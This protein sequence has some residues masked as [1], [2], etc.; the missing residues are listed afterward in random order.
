[1]SVP[2]GYVRLSRRVVNPKAVYGSQRGHALVLY[3]R[4]NRRPAP[5]TKP[6]T[7]LQLP[8]LTVGADDRIREPVNWGLVAALLGCLAL[9]GGVVFGGLLV[10]V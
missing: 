8:P 4:I 10:A 7:V 1:M 9:W 6:V 5:P 2:T 3:R